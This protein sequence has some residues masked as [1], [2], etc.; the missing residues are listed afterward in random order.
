MI[1]AGTKVVDVIDHPLF[2]GFGRLIFPTAFGRP[3]PAMTLR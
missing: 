2:S 3:D 1:T